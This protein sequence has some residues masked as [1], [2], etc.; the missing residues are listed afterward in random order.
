MAKQAKRYVITSTRPMS[1]RSYTSRPLT[2]A[3]A[4][5]YY[6]YTLECGA[7]WSHEKGNRKINRNPKTIAS[8]LTNLNNASNNTARNGCGD[9]YS[10]VE[11]VGE[12]DTA[13][14]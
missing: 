5:D 12:V 4:V 7:S 10:A 11:F 2:I 13:A 3:E 8:L 6:G 1:G 9:Y 14:A